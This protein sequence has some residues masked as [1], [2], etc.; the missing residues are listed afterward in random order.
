V[1]VDHPLGQSPVEPEVNSSLAIVSGPIAARAVAGPAAAR[2]TAAAS[3]QRAGGKPTA[4]S[5][6]A[7]GP[8]VS[9]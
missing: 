7:Y 2:A 4:A 6:A 8:W 3:S 9:A 1:G 5:A